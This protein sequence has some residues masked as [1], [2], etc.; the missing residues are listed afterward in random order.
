[1]DIRIPL[2]KGEYQKFHQ[3]SGTGI[4]VGFFELD[5]LPKLLDECFF[6][7]VVYAEDCP[8]H[9]PKDELIYQSAAAARA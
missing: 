3:P 2:Q 6:L 8:L 1:M 7:L 5:E 9:L 4:D